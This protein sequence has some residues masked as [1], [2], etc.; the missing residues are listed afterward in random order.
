[1]EETSVPAMAAGSPARD[2]PF[3]RSVAGL[4]GLTMLSIMVLACIGSLPYTLGS[5]APG[6]PAR[7][8]DGDLDGFLIPP[9]WAPMGEDERA[10][11]ETV[12]L[13]RATDALVAAKLAELRDARLP[14]AWD[15]WSQ[16][17]RQVH[18]AGLPDVDREAIEAIRAGELPADVEPPVPTQGQIDDA[19]PTFLLG[20]DKLGRDLFVRCLAGGGVSIGI[21]LAAAT[22]SVFIGTLY[23]ALSG[24]LGGRVDA[25]MMRIVD[26]LYGLPYILLVVLLAVAGDA[27]IDE[28]SSKKGAREAWMTAR[29]Q[30]VLLEQGE[31]AGKR[32]A[33][34]LLESD[35]D[36]TSA[37]RTELDTIPRLTPRE[38]TEGQRKSLEVLILLVAIGGV[39]WLT[40]ARVIRGQVLSLKAQ[41]FMEAARAMGVPVTRQF[42]RHLLPN[43]LGPVIVYATLTVPQAILQESF[44]SFLGIGVKPPLPSWGNLAAEG[45]VELN[46]VRVR[47]W[48]LVFPCILLGV[49]LLALN[50]VGEGLREAFD[51]K[52]ARK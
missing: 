31:P 43:L 3:T 48:L 46:T 42:A 18:L 20:T 16:S 25:V 47:W 1:M 8:K 36:L 14:S 52:R 17:Q 44:L 2:N 30:E 33:E 26:V 7:Y 6:E 28:W 19:R 39:S 49:T 37:L 9:T 12:A 23:G 41:P 27:L 40:M 5:S 38:L 21:G 34:A 45:L 22:I 11:L 10:R 50:F 24:Y 35:P 29:A 32:D 15:E 4:I 13:H 51:P